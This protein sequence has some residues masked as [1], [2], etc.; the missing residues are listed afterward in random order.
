MF[1]TLTKVLNNFAY[2]ACF[3]LLT[4]LSACVSKIQLEHREKQYHE[5]RSF[6]IPFEPLDPSEIELQELIIE[7]DQDG[8]GVILTNFVWF[9]TMLVSMGCLVFYRDINYDDLEN[10]I[11]EA[12]RCFDKDAQIWDIFQL[13]VRYFKYFL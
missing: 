6:L 1:P 10:H 2:R 3:F 8:N 13:Q 9:S 11:K 12:F 4:V 7:L 5:G